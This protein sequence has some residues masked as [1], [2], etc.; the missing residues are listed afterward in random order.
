[1]NRLAGTL[2]L[3][4]SVLGRLGSNVTPSPSH[5]RDSS[6]VTLGFASNACISKQTIRKTY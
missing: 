2:S 4:L 6:F 5:R 3:P 1:M